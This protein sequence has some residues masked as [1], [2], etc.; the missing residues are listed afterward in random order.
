MVN[1]NSNETPHPL[2]K[3]LLDRY[4]VTREQ[5]HRIA[6][7]LLGH[8][9]IDS[10]LTAL[11]VLFEGRGRGLSRTDPDAWWPL[12]DRSAWRSFRE[13]LQ[14]ATDRRDITDGDARLARQANEARN[15][16]LHFKTKWR[17]PSYEG[18][19]ITEEYGLHR[20]LDDLMEFL[21]R[22]GPDMTAGV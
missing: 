15:G 8:A 11:D 22:R 7:F 3:Y 13:R 19:P 1:S 10:G 12:I 21:N 4:S 14:D 9:L 5:L 18:L 16:F 6:M 17:L 20:F 2:E